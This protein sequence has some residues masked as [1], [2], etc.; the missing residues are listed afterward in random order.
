LSHHPPLAALKGSLTFFFYHDGDIH[1]GFEIMIGHGHKISLQLF[2][3][4]IQET[5][6][7]LGVRVSIPRGIPSQSGELVEILY[8]GHDTLLQVEEL[9]SHKLDESRWDVGFTERGLEV[10]PGHDLVIELHGTDIFHHAPAA[11]AR[12]WVA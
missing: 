6:S 1:H 7:L 2:M 11:P 9:I 12:N 3:K 5:L 10:I 8:H 4:T